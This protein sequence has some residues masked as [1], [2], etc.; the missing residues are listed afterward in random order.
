[1]IITCCRYESKFISRTH[2]PTEIQNKWYNLWQTTIKERNKNV[3]LDFFSFVLNFYKLHVYSI[4]KSDKE[5]FSMLFPPPNVTGDLHLGHA[6]TAT[7]QDTIIRW[8]V[9]TI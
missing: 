8:L 9:S 2:N 3:I 6:I 7:I 5:I 4:I 1:L